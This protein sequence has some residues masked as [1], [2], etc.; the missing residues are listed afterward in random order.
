MY[1]LLQH[2]EKFRVA[3]ILEGGFGGKALLEVKFISQP[4]TQFLEH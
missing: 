4:D 3:N 2:H 1:S